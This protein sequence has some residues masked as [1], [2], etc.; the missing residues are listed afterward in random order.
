MQD[1]LWKRIIEQL[2]PDFVAFFLP[3]VAEQI[4]FSQP[5]VF[6][7][8][9]LE[10][11]FPE[12]HKGRRQVDKLA[13][14]FLKSGE[15]QWILIHAEIQGYHDEQFAQRMFTY[16]YRVYDKYQQRIAALAIFADQHKDWKP[17][18]FDYRFSQ[19]GLTY[20]YPVY[21]I[22]EQDEA[23]LAHHENPFAM[24]VLA[25]LY[26]LKSH[27]KGQDTKLRFKLELTRLLL[28]RLST[29]VRQQSCQRLSQKRLRNS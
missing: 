1:A 4:D 26:A 27:R 19:T 22:L 8:K 17:A 20:F 25:A 24:V 7:D 14:V 9:E 15:A 23:L 11:L 16:F 6:L 13:K 21:K 18:Q 10:K 2:F 28:A 3:D 5:Y 12:S 29:S